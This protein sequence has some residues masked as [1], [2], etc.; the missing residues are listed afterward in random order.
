MF[1]LRQAA[2]DQV[3]LA[4]PDGIRAVDQYIGLIA[5]HLDADAADELKPAKIGTRTLILRADLEGMLQR[6]VEA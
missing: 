2:R 3:I 1:A 4:R 6:A 5:A